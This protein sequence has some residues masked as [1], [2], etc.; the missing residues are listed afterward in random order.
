MTNPQPSALVTE[1]ATKLANEISLVGQLKANLK[2]AYA[3]HNGFKRKVAEQRKRINS[4]EEAVAK[5][6]KVKEVR[7]EI[8]MTSAERDAKRR[9]D[10]LNHLNSLKAYAFDLHQEFI[11]RIAEGDSDPVLK[12]FPARIEA[13][14][15]RIQEYDAHKSF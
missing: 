14:I 7:V 5:L 3:I 1:L 10:E 12:T 15:A 6:R 2:H 11:R 4:L 8:P 9:R 13:A